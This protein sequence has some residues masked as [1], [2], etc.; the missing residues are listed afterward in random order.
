MLDNQCLPTGLI[1]ARMINRNASSPE[2]KHKSKEIE[3]SGDG[4]QEDL[5]DSRLSD[6]GVCMMWASLSGLI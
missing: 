5:K 1:S 3:V 6:I 2:E 4:T